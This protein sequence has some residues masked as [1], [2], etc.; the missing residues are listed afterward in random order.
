MPS[1]IEHSAPIIRRDTQHDSLTQPAMTPPEGV[2][3]NFV[4]P[5]NFGGSIYGVG[6]G[7]T[8]AS[9]TVFC[10]RMYT[11][12]YLVQR[13]LGSDDYTI[14]M[15]MAFALVFAGVTFKDAKYG[16]GIHQWNIPLEV[17]SPHFL[18]VSFIG[19]FGYARYPRLTQRPS[20]RFSHR[21]S[22]HWQ[23]QLQK[24]PFFFYISGYPRI[25]TFDSSFMLHC[26]W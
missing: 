6:Y 19:A 7:F 18:F 16:I 9:F 26:L 23:S 11:R 25:E 1:T 3:S 13:G 24:S 14:I 4:N 22:G 2:I 5:D 17:F 8:A 15:S 12:G 20:G 10:L 21:A